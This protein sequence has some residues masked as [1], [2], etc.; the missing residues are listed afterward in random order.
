MN[1]ILVFLLLGVILLRLPSL[2]EPNRYADEDIYLT[3]GMALR[4]GRVLYRDI[5]DNKPPLIYFTAAVARNVANF[6]F[7]L[8]L[9]N[10]IHVA[11]FYRIA[12]LILGNN[13]GM[14]IICVLFVMLSTLPLLEGNIAN[15][16]IFMIMPVT[17]A[18]WLFWKNQASGSFKSLLGVGGLLAFGFLFKVTAVFEAGAVGIFLLFYQ[19]ISKSLVDKRVWGLILGFGLPII[20]SIGL[21]YLWGAGEI[22]VRSALLQN[23]DYL[24]SW[25]G[26][27]SRGLLGRAGLIFTLI[28]LVFLMRNKLNRSFIFLTIWLLMSLLGALLSSRPYPHYLLQIT[29]SFTLLIGAVTLTRRALAWFVVAITTAFAAWQIKTV[30]FWYYRSWPYYFNFLQYATGKISKPEYDNFF[31]G[32]SRNKAISGYVRQHTQPGEQVF[33]WGTEPAIYVLTNRLPVGKYVTSYH[34]RDFDKTGE[35]FSQIQAT[36]PEAIVIFASEGDYLGFVPWVKSH[37][38]LAQEAQD[39]QIYLQPNF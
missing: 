29:A 37:Y 10:L 24:S 7:I 12:K 26:G 15:G 22:Y 13:R 34:I 32:V 4:E 9:W 28:G 33:V 2:F 18:M 16:E 20:V 14:V 19:P 5:H 38:S 8:L 23:I 21:A 6:R 11:I 31:Q 17:A 35:T 1:K 25:T 36:P 39:A 30:N 27:S 3:I